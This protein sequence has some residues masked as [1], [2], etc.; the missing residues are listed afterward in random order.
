MS[1]DTAHDDRFLHLDLNTN[2][3]GEHPLLADVGDLVDSLSAYPSRR[4]DELRA[5]LA[6]R[7][8]APAEAFVCG[9][10]GDA[11]IDIAFRALADPGDR[12]AFPW[13]GFEMYPY[14]A[15][16]R[17]LDV[18]RVPLA[19][20][21]L[22]LPLDG[23]VDAGADVVILANP[24]NP[25][26]EAAPRDAI[27]E[28]ADAV[29]GHLVVDEAYIEFADQAS[30][31]D[32]A[33]DRQDLVVVRTFSKAHGLAGLRVGYAVCHPETAATLDG[34][35]PPFHLDAIGEQIAVRAL[36]DPTFRDETVRTVKQQRP[37]LSAALADHG[38]EPLPS[39]ANFVLAKAPLDPSD[40]ADRL[41]DRDILVRVFDGEPRLADHVRVTVGRAEHVDRLAKALDEVV[42]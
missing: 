33:L 42:A 31:A 21:E 28:L 12:I 40:L 27:L 10:G 25:T 16:L 5:A 3:V 7:F 15:K 19:D 39:Q 32:R 17:D 8:D 30:L 35:R 9:N 36:A 11:L 22:E 24:N 26:G 38:F 37:R 1:Y 20:D 29:D 18:E 14:F 4:S 2:L 13:P 41:A 6:D 23:L 34:A